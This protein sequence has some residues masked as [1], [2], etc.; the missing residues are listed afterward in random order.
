M[1]RRLS[2]ALGIGAV[3]IAL[4]GCSLLEPVDVAP[5]E[6]AA[7]EPGSRVLR[8]AN[9]YEPSHPVNRCGVEPMKEELSAAGID[10]RSYPAG[11]LG[12]EAALVEQ[13]AT[14]ALDIGIAG[15][16]FLG[17]WYED[18]AVV[19]GAYLF[20][21]V[22]EF[23]EAT[24]G[25]VLADVYDRM[26]EETGLRV[27]SNWYYGTRHIT[28]NKPVTAPEDLQG[29]KIRTPDA[30]LYLINFG[31]MGATA[32]P[33]ALSEVYLGLQQNAIDAQENPIPTIASSNFQEVQDY[34]SL[35]GHMVQG[36][37]IVTTD[38]LLESLEPAQRDALEAAI[39]TARISVRDCIVEEEQQVLAEWKDTGAIE[40]V[41]DVDVDAFQERI[42]A[43]LPSQVPW[44]DLYLQIQ[45]DLA[46][47]NE[48]EQ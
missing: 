33:M 10:L 34:V 21:D 16:S 7:P 47:E 11:Q 41:E 13:V 37:Q 36:V 4:S 17:E 24:T 19:D 44:G 3:A 26:A 25:P 35:T 31:I 6:V 2:A 30:P 1:R 40:V 8:F 12:S 45:A 22:D 18:A 29:L 9:G 15:G 43:E 27:A 5:E 42:A 48:E 32:T 39:E 23:D 20:R 14:G 38:R 28:A 46:T